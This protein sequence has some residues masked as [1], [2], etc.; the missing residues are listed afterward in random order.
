MNLPPRSRAGRWV[1]LV[2]GLLALG[3]AVDATLVELNW[4]EVVRSVE[5]L[6]MTRPTAPD[7]TLVHISDIHI[8]SLGYRERQAIEIINDARPDIIVVSGDL[9][10]GANHPQ[11]LQTFL[12]SLRSRYGKFLVWGNHDYW[13]RVPGTWGPEVVA[14]AGFTL[15]RN[16]STALDYPGGRIVIAGL[17]DP[18][19]GHDNLRLAMSRVSRREACILVAHSPE[20]VRNLGNWDIDLVL[21]GHTHGGQVRLPIVGALWVPFGS[22]DHLE[23]WFDVPPGVRLHVSR[24]LGWSWLPVRFLC[25]PT[26][27][28][29]TL[30]AGTPTDKRARSIIGQS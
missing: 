6:P 17:D 2:G 19:T 7:L 29:I 13:D 24:G 25:R 5:Y 9:V 1:S 3:V 28:I 12:G 26:I 22:R 23:G 20:V 30:R 10:R 8:A 16:S 4:I 15:L 14:R 27:D 18:I 21:A 11:E